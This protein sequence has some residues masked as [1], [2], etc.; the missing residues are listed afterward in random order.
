MASI[1]KNTSNNIN[2]GND[3]NNYPTEVSYNEGPYK[4]IVRRTD[5]GVNCGYIVL[6]QFH[7]YDGIDC[8]NIPVNVHGGL[9]YSERENGY[10]V[11]GFDTCHVGDF[12]PLI[13]SYQ[14]NYNWSH[15]D[16]LNELKYLM[17]QL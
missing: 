5:N 12:N 2:I 13:N 14:D 15:L 17:Y 3:K 8:D 6:P 7:R 16:V 9:T 10:W 1:D 11:I 4:L